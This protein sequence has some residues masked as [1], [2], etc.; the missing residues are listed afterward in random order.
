MSGPDTTVSSDDLPS[1]SDDEAEQILRSLRAIIRGITIRSKQL[2]RE[3]GLTLP[4]VL[5]LRIIGEA[6]PSSFT[7]AEVARRVHLSPATVT[8]IIDRLERN[9]TIVRERDQVDRRK[10][11]LNVTLKGQEWLA[12]LPALFQDRAVQ[13]L[14]ELDSA[15]R[16]EILR[17]LR[18]VLELFD[19]SA[20]ESSPILTPGESPHQAS[21]EF[22]GHGDV[23]Q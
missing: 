23:E 10:V 16:R 4:Q 6:E 21:A 20:A 7:S 18:R 11:Y 1:S 22:T 5:C 15:E 3:T 2:F 17:S 12:S 14:N 13:R 9:G 8:G 19:A